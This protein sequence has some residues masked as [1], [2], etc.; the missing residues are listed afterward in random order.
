MLRVT[1]NL[2]TTKLTHPASLLISFH[3]GGELCHGPNVKLKRRTA[4]YLRAALAEAYRMSRFVH[5]AR[6]VV[7]ATQTQNVAR[8]E[9]LADSGCSPTAITRIRAIVNLGA[10]TIW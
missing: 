7:L 10:P 1:V 4:D 9:L 2:F 3:A 5:V 8:L 6:S